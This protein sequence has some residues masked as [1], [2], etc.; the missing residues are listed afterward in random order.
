MFRSMSKRKRLKSMVAV[1]LLWQLGGAVTGFAAMTG[2]GPTQ[3]P[4]KTAAQPCQE[5][6]ASSAAGSDVSQSEHAVPQGHSGT[7]LGEPPCCQ[8]DCSCVGSQGP[9]AVHCAVTVRLMR[10]DYHVIGDQD[11]PPVVSQITE[12]FRPP[13]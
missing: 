10:A 2:P 6:V 13:I 4:A 9:P 11:S 8:S 12:F 1:L 3:A 7:T 5:Q